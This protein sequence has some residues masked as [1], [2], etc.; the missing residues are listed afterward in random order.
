[1]SEVYFVGDLHLGHKNIC[2]YREQFQ[3]QEEHDEYVMNKVLETGTKRDTLVL[4]GD[5]FFT[6]E[7]LNALRLF[8]KKFRKI[9]FILGNHDSDNAQRQANI[10]TIIKEDLVDEIHSLWRYKEFWVSHAPIHPEEL[11]GKKNLHGHCHSYVVSDTDNYRCVSL[12]QINY[13]P[14]PLKEIRSEF[15][16][17]AQEDIEEV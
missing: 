17:D 15:K 14:I 9:V 7:S 12:E 6:E 11:R 1:M 5:C 13:S 4:L 3:T 8:R 16:P 10:R 2:K